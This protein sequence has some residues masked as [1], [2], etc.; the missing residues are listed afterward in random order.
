MHSQPR[1]DGTRRG[2]E[3]VEITAMNLKDQI[4]RTDRA[5]ELTRKFAAEQRALIGKDGRRLW[6]FP[7]G[8]LVRG[9]ALFGADMA[10][11]SCLG[12]DTGRT[13]LPYQVS[14]PPKW[15]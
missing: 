5:Q 10:F 13:Y 15:G 7:I 9:A 2:T 8:G 1:R 14:R 12:R 6:L 11:G 4:A 3:P